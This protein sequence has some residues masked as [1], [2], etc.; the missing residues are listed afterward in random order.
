M[1][2]SSCY[3]LLEI[4][5]GTDPWK[6]ERLK[7]VTAS[8]IQI[9]LGI[10]PYQKPLDLLKE[11]ITGQEADVSSYKQVLFAKGHSAEKSAREWVEAD[12]KIK[13]S[14]AV[15]LSKKC[16]DLMASLDGF[17]PEKNWILEAKYMGA[18]SLI[19]VKSKKLKPHHVCQIQGQ[20]LA[21]GAE[22]CI[23]FATDGNGDS[24]LVEIKPDPEY[25][26]K[27]AA[28]VTDFMKDIQDYKQFKQNLIT[29]YSPP[30]LPKG[31]IFRVRK[32]YE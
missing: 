32:R 7:R 18:K 28:A 3:E 22:K 31:E 25:A 15:V 23:Y 13:F 24:A 8:Q 11:K 16:P 26:T 10:C 9:I 30:K 12:L 14:P 29:K 2:N 1:T 5:Q 21:T 4:E 20:L 17:N 6:Q 27:I 19:E